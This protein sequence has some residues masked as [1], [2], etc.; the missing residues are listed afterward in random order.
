MKQQMKEDN[1][2]N[3]KS[4]YNYIIKLGFFYCSNRIHS[5]SN[6]CFSSLGSRLFLRSPSS[7]LPF[8]HKISY[9][10]SVGCLFRYPCILFWDQLHVAP[11]EKWKSCKMFDK[12]R[13]T[14]ILTQETQWTWLSSLNLHH[15]W[16]RDEQRFHLSLKNAAMQWLSPLTR[17]LL[18]ISG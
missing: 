15:Q 11:K 18:W 2:V 17:S 8:S 6:F 13:N 9:S 12:I 3:N 14:K 4:Q 1:I 7:S 10:P 16:S 5:Q